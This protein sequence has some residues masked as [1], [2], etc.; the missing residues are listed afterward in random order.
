M[1]RTKHVP[2]PSAVLHSV[3]PTKPF[4]TI[5]P[6]FVKGRFL[7]SGMFRLDM[8]MLI[9]LGGICSAFGGSHRFHCPRRASLGA[10]LWEREQNVREL[11]GCEAK[12]R[13][14]QSL[15]PSHRWGGA[16]LSIS[17]RPASQREN[18]YHVRQAQ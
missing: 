1:G 11:T 12:K 17:A 5:V 4:Y 16:R 10:V 2:C 9:L 8:L 15:A 18:P 14:C 6:V 13:G 7:L 3:V